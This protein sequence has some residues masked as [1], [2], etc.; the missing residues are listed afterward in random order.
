LIEELESKL[1][2]FDGGQRKTAL[3]ELC[4]KVAAGRVDLPEPGTDVNIHC[5]TFF[6]YNTYGYSPSKFAWLA[7]KQASGPKGLRRT[8]ITRLRS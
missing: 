7:R 4:E 8:G 6:S 5:H 3:L 1:D 2:S